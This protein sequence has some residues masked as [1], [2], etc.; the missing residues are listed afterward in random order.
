MEKV[1]QDIKVSI[2]IPTLLRATLNE[3]KQA[4][5]PQCEQLI[6]IPGSDTIGAKLNK[7]FSKADG[8][9][10]MKCDD[11][12]EYGPNYV[13]VM[14][15]AL[16]DEMAIALVSPF[17]VLWNAQVYQLPVPFRSGATLTFPRAVWEQVRFRENLETD[18]DAWWLHDCSLKGIPIISVSSDQ[19][20]ARR[21]SEGHT[22]THTHRESVEDLLT[23]IGPI[24]TQLA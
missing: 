24:Q 23:R 22:W 19:F 10:F 3:V 21:H 16:G 4:L 2:V 7:G 6:V 18:V 20:T 1:V 15:D 17:R 5:Q 11:D 13:Q 8:D 9:F 14:L 12:D